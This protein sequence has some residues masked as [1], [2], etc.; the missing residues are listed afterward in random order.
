MRQVAHL[1]F[2]RGAHAKTMGLERNMARERTCGLLSAAPA[3]QSAG[4]KRRVHVRWELLAVGKLS[5]QVRHGI[6][7]SVWNVGRHSEFTHVYK[8]CAAGKRKSGGEVGSHR[9]PR[10]AQ[11]P[12]IGEAPLRA[13]PETRFRSDIYKRL[14]SI[15]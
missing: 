1:C 4:E 7:G 5:C 11:K 13:L 14:I 15:L 12:P 10:N 3:A 9:Q 8:G 6:G 2:A